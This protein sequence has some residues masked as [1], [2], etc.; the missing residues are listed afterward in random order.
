[1]FK[2]SLISG[3]VSSILF[4]SLSLAQT[5]AWVEENTEN[6]E[7]ISTPSEVGE[8]P[9]VN[10]S[11]VVVT[12]ALKEELSIEYSAASIAH[13]NAKNVDRLNATSLA[14]LLVYEPGVSVDRSRTGGL[15]DIRIRGMGENRVM[16]TVDGA[17]L[18]NSFSFGPVSM[19]RNYFD[20]DAMKS[21][22]IIK[23]PMSSLYGGSALVGGIFMETK[24]PSD[25]IKEGNKFGGEVKA[26]YRSANKETLVTGTVAGHLTDSLSAFGR[27]TF[28][29][30][31]ELENHKGH[32]SKSNTLGPDRAY[33]NSSDTKAYNFLTKWVFSPNA[34]HRFSLS[35]EDFKNT[36]DSTLESEIS[37]VTSTY[38]Q[39]SY[40]AK[41]RNKRFQV[42]LR[43]DFNTV[44]PMFDRGFWQ[45]YYQK[46]KAEQWT[47]EERQMTRARYTVDRDRYSTFENKTLGLGAEFSKFIE[48]SDS[49]YHNITYGINYKDSKIT[50]SRHGDTR[51][52]PTYASIE[53]ETFPN[54]SFPD[55]KVRE[56][57]IFAQDR[58]GFMDGKFEVIAGLRYDHYKLSPEH[59]TAFESANQGV[60]PP[61]SMSEGRVSKRLAL[62]WHPTEENSLF[63]NYSEGFRAPTYSA[64]NMGFSNPAHGYTSRSNPNLRPET[65]RSYELG[66]NYVDEKK[67]FGLTGFY[68][69][70]KN[71]IEEQSMVGRDRES[72]LMVYQA[73]NLEKSRIYGVEAKTRMEL[74]TLQDGQGTV[75]FNASIAYAKGKDK[76]TDQPINSVDP[77]T[78]V[79]GLD[80]TYSDQLYLS[81]RFKAVRAKKL[82]DISQ[83]SGSFSS[84]IPQLPGYGTFDLIAEYKPQR[85][86][87]IN[88]GLY[89]IFNKEY[90][91][92]NEWSAATTPAARKR[93]SNPGFNAAISVKYEF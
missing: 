71:F 26:G 61:E 2:R 45:V 18:P 37:K 10:L 12:S 23:G 77:L 88:A 69:D 33:P 93:A 89:N 50:T 63:V 19:D 58:I 30:P 1:M 86:I 14:D 11:K 42:N 87:T 72:G 7:G 36:T 78:A 49:I 48:Q 65:S 79:I 64:V 6:A 20:I 24:D 31:D 44:T 57:G 82:R 47:M 27:I 59:G 8:T 70:Y 85:D 21:I 73:I 83:L 84:G 76:K 28:T 13:F 62:L 22:D 16:I 51:R 66:W 40:D 35:V 54:K 15:G 25:F 74:F 60:L 38:K 53:T 80:Y 3:L 56:I 52:L 32:A 91:S 4:S 81:A 90:F 43:H 41:D 29:N 75:S 9:V 5:L 68:V 92:W 46:N 55:S 39:L 34:D 67:S 17:P